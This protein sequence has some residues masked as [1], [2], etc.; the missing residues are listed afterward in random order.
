MQLHCL[1]ELL[2][3]QGFRVVGAEP[4][5]PVSLTSARQPPISS[6]GAAASSGTV[7]TFA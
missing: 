4:C 7:R 1:T 6:R 5:G 2:G 3:F